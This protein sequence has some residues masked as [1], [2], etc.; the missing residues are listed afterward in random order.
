MDETFEGLLGV[1][2]L[3]DDI[4]IIGRTREEHDTNLRATLERA[5]TRNLKL[6]LDKLTV[7][8]QEVEYFGHILSA[9][10]LKPDP[11]QGKGNSGHA[12]QN[13]VTN[14]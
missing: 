9:D 3:V 13:I 6:N 14:I 7:G 11:H 10:G 1:T 4:I 2:P 5:A 8:A 12:S